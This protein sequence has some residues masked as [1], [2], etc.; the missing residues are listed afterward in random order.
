MK[1]KKLL[2]S[3]TPLFNHD[4]PILIKLISVKK[5]MLI[6]SCLIV[7]LLASTPDLN[8]QA[9]TVVWSG[10]DVANPEGLNTE[11]DNQTTGWTAITS[12]SQSS[13]LWSDAHSIPFSFEFFGT[14]VTQFKVSQN[15]LITFDVSASGTTVNNNTSLP[16]AN[17]PD[18]TIAGFWDDF[19][20]SP[21]TGANDIVYTKIFGTSPNRQFWIKYYSF[22]YS[23][24]EYSYFSI[25]LDETTN[26]VYIVRNNTHSSSV[27]AGSSTVG[28]QLN[29]TTA[30]QTSN[31]PNVFFDS[32]FNNHF[33]QPYG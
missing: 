23:V 4:N 31:S 14:S 30:L 28:V 15:G 18:N 21:P 3:L 29:S 6:L 22:E 25:V 8:A 26:K 10:Y 24:F 17:L 20:N 16:N 27:A 12:G 5:I 13:N 32:G 19:T 33:C 9:Y 7:F 11:P 2:L 1:F